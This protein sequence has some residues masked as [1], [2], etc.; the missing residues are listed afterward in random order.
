[1]KNLLSVS[2]NQKV[3]VVYYLYGGINTVKSGIV[4]RITP[5]KKDI[6][7]EF[8][9]GVT[10]KFNSFG[11]NYSTTRLRASILNPNNEDDVLVVNKFRDSIKRAKLIKSINERLLNLKTEDLEE[12]LNNN[13]EL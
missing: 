8:S 13:L 6:I 11:T 2:L 7:V 12:I 3:T 10:E 9:D 5:N 4:K 1:M